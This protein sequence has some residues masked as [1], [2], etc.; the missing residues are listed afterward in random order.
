MDTIGGVKG[1]SRLHGERSARHGLLLSALAFFFVSAILISFLTG[2]LTSTRVPVLLAFGLL[3]A[4]CLPF[5]RNVWQRQA[6]FFQPIHFYAILFALYYGIRTLYLASGPS[7]P[8]F[9]PSL[10]ADFLDRS[11]LPIGYALVGL[12][13]F[14]TGY[15]STGKSLAKPRT[16]LSYG[17][18][19]TDNH[20][21]Q[22]PVSFSYG[23]L[24]YLLGLIGILVSIRTGQ[25]LFFARE[26]I[27]LAFVYPL[28]LLIEVRTIGIIILWTERF[29]VSSSLVR[30]L[31]L[32]ILIVDIFLRLAGGSKEELTQL[33]LIVL[34]V[35]QYQRVGGIS[36]RVL[37]INAILMLAIFTFLNRYRLS[38]SILYGSSPINSLEGIVWLYQSFVDALSNVVQQGPIQYL[39]LII[40]TVANRFAGLDSLVAGVVFTPRIGF[41]WGATIW[42]AFVAPI[43]RIL[44]PS[45]PSS[46]YHL[47]FQY[48]YGGVPL[49]NPSRSAVMTLTDLYI[50]WGVVGIAV[51]MFLLGKICAWLYQRY[52]A[53]GTTI[54]TDRMLIYL[55]ILLPLIRV[56]STAGGI[57]A[58]LLTLG[59][60]GFILSLPLRRSR[61]F[62]NHIYPKER[63]KYR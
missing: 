35:T 3:F 57:I 5:M 55:V 53:Q 59:L 27:D 37:A 43:P 10:G 33:I 24:L 49:S 7:D 34:I 52:I 46:E 31:S 36:K 16:T 1:T 4:C 56:E 9:L 2:E 30:W 60:L 21:S 50:N 8:V 63:L 44:W 47:W 17:G 51:G 38:Y 32:L 22:S 28:R 58:Q 15:Y 54:S 42:P 62:Q 39:Q 6:D 61:P 12:L 13:C 48:T 40:T 18:D 14:Y 45:K 20:R 41:Q 11:A 19:H 29:R 26:D 23:V 25:F